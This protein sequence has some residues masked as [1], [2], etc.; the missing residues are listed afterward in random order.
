MREKLRSMALKRRKLLQPHLYPA[1]ANRIRLLRVDLNWTLKVAGDL[2][3][4]LYPD[5]VLARLDIPEEQ[6]WKDRDLAYRDWQGLAG[7]IFNSIFGPEFTV[8]MEEGEVGFKLEVSGLFFARFILFL[9][10]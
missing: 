4:R 6:Y 8:P 2:L 10:C 3:K 7:Q 5:R 9:S 1:D